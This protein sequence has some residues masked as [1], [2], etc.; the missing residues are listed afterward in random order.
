MLSGCVNFRSP[1]SRV[2]SLLVV[3]ACCPMNAQADS[4]RVDDTWYQ[5]VY[6]VVTKDFYHILDPEDGTTTS[7]SK[8]RQNIS[9]PKFTKDEAERAALRARWEE[10]AKLREKADA[11]DIEL[12]VRDKRLTNAGEEPRE[13]P[14]VKLSPQERA[15]RQAAWQA[16]VEERRQYQEARQQLLN[17]R[18]GIA[19]EPA[20]T[21]GESGLPLEGE[22][23]PTPPG[24]R[25]RPEAAAE[26]TPEE[27][28]EMDRIR[29]EPYFSS[30][31]ERFYYEQQMSAEQERMLAEQ[32]YWEEMEA[33]G[34]IDSMGYGAVPPVAP[35][36]DPTTH[37]ANPQR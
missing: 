10:A 4:I 27:L 36:P 13:K 17:E 8:K 6:V 19:P 12:R 24:P 28:A 29:Q 3:S 23:A 33:Q 34:Y 5:D 32:L 21:E 1:V 15:A 30:E 7:V 35:E 11:R 18:A 26:P 25:P 22:A 31:Q 20:A 16:F 2:I 14:K 37:N 9:E